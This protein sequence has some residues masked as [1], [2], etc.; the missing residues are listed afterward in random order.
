MNDDFR[1]RSGFENMALLDQ[2]VMQI[3]EIVD[4][5]V[6]DHPYSAVLVGYRL[7][8]TIE[9]NDRKSPVAETDS[10]LT[11]KSPRRPD[12]DEPTHRSSL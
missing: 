10:A 12:H 1:V 7:M 9:I 4:L 2:I 5:S 8:S 6:E 11:R 3:S